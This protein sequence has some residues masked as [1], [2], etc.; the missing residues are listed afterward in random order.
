MNKRPAPLKLF[1]IWIALSAVIIL[2]GVLLMCL[3]GFNDSAE[4]PQ[5]SVVEVRYGISIA[6]DPEKEDKLAADCE[7]IFEEYHVR[8]QE[9]QDGMGVTSLTDVFIYRYVFGDDATETTLKEA[10]G[11]IGTMAETEWPDGDVVATYHF[12]ENLPFGTYL[13]RGA[14]AVIVGAVVVLAY[15]AIR[16]GVG[17][18]LSGLVLAVNDSVLTVSLFAI[19]R[20][21]VFA[22]APLLFGSV[23]GILSIL[24]WM[25]FCMKLRENAKA[26]DAGSRTAEDSVL[27]AAKDS[28]RWIALFLG[29]LAFGLV[30]G[31][32]LG[33]AGVRL[34]LL[35]MLIP[36]AAAAYSSLLLGPALHARVKPV[37]DKFKAKRKTRYLGKKK[38]EK[39]EKTAE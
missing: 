21:P 22:F 14:V 25:V 31:G 39:A 27:L 32:A 18:A 8:P 34:L 37:F 4:R 11:A 26:P 6:N 36:V 10:A 35:P 30:I 9:R 15:I 12:E 5:N 17:C 28:R 16:F 19:T 38:G 2:A 33:T 29:A 24:A 20:I 13:W 3:L 23:A 7:K 1:P